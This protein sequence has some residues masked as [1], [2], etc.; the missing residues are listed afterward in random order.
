MGIGVRSGGTRHT[1]AHTHAHSHTHCSS[2]HNAAATAAQAPTAAAPSSQVDAWRLAP[3]PLR[4]LSLFYEPLPEPPKW[5]GCLCPPP[6]P[7]GRPA[8]R[9]CHAAE[10]RR[11]A[12][13]GGS[14]RGWK[15]PTAPAPPAGVSGGDGATSGLLRREAPFKLLPLEGPGHSGCS[16]G[17]EHPGDPVFLLTT[18]PELLA[19]LPRPSRPR[20]SP[21][22]PP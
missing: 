14:P 9:G 10:G 3:P 22:G 19:R 13:A 12:A 8:G 11:E 15:R 20:G 2:E 7:P 1:Q 18:S 6:S 17:A 16:C 21:L 4:P 5:P